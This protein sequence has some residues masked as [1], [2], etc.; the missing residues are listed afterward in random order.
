MTTMGLV[1]NFA[2]MM[3]AVGHLCKNGKSNLANDMDSAGG[4]VS[5][6]LVSSPE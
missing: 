6:K 5:L 1:H 3:T 2:G 4:L